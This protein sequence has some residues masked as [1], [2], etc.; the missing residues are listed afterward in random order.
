MSDYAD[1][2]VDIRGPGQPSE[3]GRERFDCVVQVQGSG[4]RRGTFEPD[5]NAL[6]IARPGA[7]GDTLGTA[8]ATPALLAALAEA[9]ALAPE[10]ARLRLQI[11]ERAE[12][13]LPLRW[14]LV[15]LNESVEQGAAYDAALSERTAF[16]RY[17]P[18]AEQ[19]RTP[20]S[21]PVLTVLVALANPLGLGPDL[22][23]PVQ[24]EITSLLDEFVSQKLTEVSRLRVIVM[25]GRTPISDALRQ[26]TGQANWTIVDGSTSLRNI[27][28]VLQRGCHALHLVCH[29]S[30]SRKGSELALEDDAGGLTRTQD[31]LLAAW[32]HPRLQLMLL[33]SCRSAAPVP[34]A[35]IATQMLHRG[36]P[37]VVAMQDLVGMIDARHFAAA[38]YRSLLRDGLVDV[39]ANRGRLAMREAQSAANW[40][41]PALYMRLKGG[42]LWSP[43]AVREYVVQKQHDLTGSPERG[44]LPLKV[45]ENIKGLDLK[46]GDQAVGPWFTMSARTS[47]LVR[48][49][50]LAVVLTGP[51]GCG[52]TGE[53]RRLFLE[54]ADSYLNATVNGSV[55]PVFGML[56]DLSPW[57]VKGQDGDGA[58]ALFSDFRQIAQGLPVPERLK[59]RRFAFIIE[60]DR[61]LAR[62]ARFHALN[63]LHLLLEKFPGSAC[64]LT[65]GEADLADLQSLTKSIVALVVQPMNP[66]E[67]RGYLRK[68]DAPLLLKLATNRL[69]DLAASPWL[70]GQMREQM[71]MQSDGALENR[72]R[73]LDACVARMLSKFDT[74]RIP[75]TMAER[76]LEAIAW[77]IQEKRPTETTLVA[78]ARLTQ[79]DVDQVIAGVRG[80][81]EFS[82]ADMCRELAECDLL[83][84]SGN[85][86]VRFTSRSIRAL[87]AARFLAKSSQPGDLVD[88]LAATFG[89]LGRLRY[90]TE[91][92]VIAA[93]LP[94]FRPYRLALLKSILTGSS[95]LEGEQAYLAARLY[96]EMAASKDENDRLFDSVAAA[97][98]GTDS[99]EFAET[100][101]QIVDSLV[102]RA[103]DVEGRPYDDRR[104]AV[105]HLGKMR[106][107]DAVPHLIKIAV[108]RVRTGGPTNAGSARFEYAGLR[109]LAMDGLWQQVDATLA[110]VKKRQ[111]AEGLSR[112]IA[113][114]TEMYKDPTR[115][116]TL[117]DILKADN[118]EHAPIAAFALLQF[119]PEVIERLLLPLYWNTLRNWELLWC[120]T[121]GLAL[122][123][124]DWLAA[125]V[126]DPAIERHRATPASQVREDLR[127][128]LCY[129]IRELDVVPADSPRRQY[130]EQ[131]LTEGDQKSRIWALRALAALTDQ[132]TGIAGT[133]ALTPKRLAEAV[134]TDDR[135]MLDPIGIQPDWRWKQGALESLRDVGDTES[136]EIIRAARST[137]H[138]PL[139]LRL[140]FQ[141]AEEI[142]WRS[143]G[144]MIQVTT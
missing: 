49:P 8:L 28:T 5:L 69:D 10:G 24:Q 73:V 109:F 95:M 54:L 65:W 34:F 1:V 23:I 101:R 55:A 96:V 83:A 81:S 88:N 84:L 91:T 85:G 80:V 47:E 78:A 133:P 110:E 120:I 79:A 106:H 76:V 108:D 21:D 139:L 15:R 31:V 57:A 144:G 103:R 41:I 119:G 75:I 117:L 43:D 89:R 111:D 129:L 99:R 124:D 42:L 38:F 72:A 30:T 18:L 14:E 112:V 22:E 67:V 3:Q 36:V 134:V 143:I 130:L 70:L 44:A 29:G 2:L 114:W 126:I 33:Q 107:P 94:E 115:T 97:S 58:A 20:P 39:A 122:L 7:Y 135:A 51:P 19:D 138:D 60:R 105:E 35:N 121:E 92:L 116:E 102:W 25:P 40:S 137:L 98:P 61:G 140:S 100:V 113:A 127:A 64:L 74:S 26:R 32:Y 141:V 87:L 52:K 27:Q 13:L 11:D 104:K 68:H 45:I 90:W 93:A 132:P 123:A 63:G 4:Q 66:L 53:A 71:R 48:R 125:K 59:G 17:I 46:P 128:M 142:Y 9:R 131:A 16:S 37:A 86:D 56:S 50:D 62:S 12:T 77:K 6:D 136:F 82:I 118:A